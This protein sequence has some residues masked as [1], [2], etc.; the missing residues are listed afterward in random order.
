[1]WMYFSRVALFIHVICFLSSRRKASHLAM[2]HRPLLILQ[3]D[4][5]KKS[6]QLHE[7]K[8]SPSNNDDNIFWGEN[9]GIFYME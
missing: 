7:V 4:A 3:F 8:E 1:M 2:T 9:F 5:P 6:R